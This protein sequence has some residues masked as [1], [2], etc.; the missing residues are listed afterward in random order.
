MYKIDIHR[1][2]AEKT[3]TGQLRGYKLLKSIG[4]MSRG[5]VHKINMRRIFFISSFALESIVLLV[6]ISERQD[7]GRISA[8]IYVI[9]LC[10]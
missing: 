3:L 5:P 6:A 1:L 10:A 4:M 9:G 2:S 7:V 8:R